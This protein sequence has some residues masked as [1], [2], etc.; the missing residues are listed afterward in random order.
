MAPLLTA[1]GIS[2]SVRGQAVFSPATFTVAAGEGLAV[3]GHNG[4]GKTTLLDIIAGIRTADSGDLSLDAKIGYVMQRDGF[5]DALSCA[6]NLLFEAALCGLAGRGA[7]ERALYCADLCGAGGFL[8]K[9]VSKCSGG[10]RARLAMAAAL[11]PEPGILLLDEPFNAIDQE[12]RSGIKGLLMRM[13]EHGTAFV[14]VSHNPSDY[15]GLCERTLDL[16]EAEV[17]AI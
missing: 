12:T 9:R 3:R 15:E 16:P 8:A 5:Q 7:R 10:M 6:D 11:I 13:K 4:S 17:G 14:V 2:K 1:T